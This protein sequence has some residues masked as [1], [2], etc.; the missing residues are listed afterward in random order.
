LSHF[1]GS[2][3]ALIALQLLPADLVPNPFQTSAN[4]YTQSNNKSPDTKTPLE[5]AKNSPPTPGST[6]DP[7]RRRTIH[8]VLS[9]WNAQ[10]FAPRSIRITAQIKL[11]QS[12]LSPAISGI[13]AK[14]FGG[15]TAL[16]KAISA[17]DVRSVKLL[18]SKG[19][20]PDAK[21][22]GGEPAVYR[23]VSKVCSEST[24]TEELKAKAEADRQIGRS[25]AGVW[26]GCGCE[27]AGFRHPASC[28]G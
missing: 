16:Y 15:E 18:L 10:F 21:A 22:Y 28:G 17:S 4:Q 23:A 24:D 25:A 7:S 26:R 2:L 19:A 1:D 27:T 6:S 12:Q 8:A 13:D 11:A 3:P 14:P 9:E 20:N 5:P